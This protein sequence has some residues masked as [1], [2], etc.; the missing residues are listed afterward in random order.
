M[1]YNYYIFEKLKENT[2]VDILKE[3]IKVDISFSKKIKILKKVKRVDNIVFL[4]SIICMFYII[5][6]AITINTLYLFL[7]I[8]P[9]IFFLDIMF[10]RK[11]YKTLTALTILAIPNI[12]GGL[13]KRII[14]LINADYELSI[15]NYFLLKYYKFIIYKKMKKTKLPKKN[16]SIANLID[17]YFDM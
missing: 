11:E 16:I 5:Y 10:K 7:I 12:S 6:K 1:I 14:K 17:Y 4:I 9:Y 15:V 2:H 3:L 8:F 13:L